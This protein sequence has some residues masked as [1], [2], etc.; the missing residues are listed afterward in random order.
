[1]PELFIIRGLPGSG[2]T[3]LGH[4]LS[5]LVYAADDHFVDAEGR[6]NFDPSR[7]GAAHAQCQENVRKALEYGCEKVAVTNTFTQRWEIQPYLNIVREV[8]EDLLFQA[9]DNGEEDEFKPI[10]ITVIDLFDGGLHD[11]ELA[12]RNI[13]GVPAAGIAAMRS[14]YEFDWKNG[15]PVPPWERK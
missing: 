12:A 10:K 6:Y 14:R 5:L 9:V 15:N 8:N 13:H 2:K 7:L 1:M 3:S 4:K 11:E